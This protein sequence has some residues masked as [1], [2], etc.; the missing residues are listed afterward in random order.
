MIKRI[1][2]WLDAKA[3]TAIQERYDNGYGYAATQM[4]KY[5]EEPVNAGLDFTVFDT[6]IKDAVIAVSHLQ[7]KA[8]KLDRIEAENKD[9]R[10]IV[11]LMQKELG[12]LLVQLDEVSKPQALSNPPASKPKHPFRQEDLPEW[13]EWVAQDANGHWYAYSNDPTT[14]WKNID[15]L[16]PNR[17]NAI[18]GGCEFLYDGDD[19]PNWK[20]TLAR[21]KPER[22]PLSELPFDIHD[23]PQWANWVAQDEGGKWYAYEKK[24]YITDQD[25]DQWDEESKDGNI[26]TVCKSEVVGDWRDTLYEIPKRESLKDFEYQ[27]D[28]GLFDG[29]LG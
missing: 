20:Y 29:Q 14:E 12:R 5:G 6:G 26:D 4:L 13:A 9:L 19:N 27:A 28:A 1:E 16:Y 15:G 25:S 17:W 11:Q 22:R 8:K 7:D 23:L 21:V 10:E 3:D 18:I 24:P 2:K